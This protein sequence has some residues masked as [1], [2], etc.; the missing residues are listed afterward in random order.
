MPT[1]HLPTVRLR[2]GDDGTAAIEIA[3]PTEAGDDL[4]AEWQIDYLPSEAQS[5]IRAALADMD[6]NEPPLDVSTT[7][8][9][10]SPGTHPQ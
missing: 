1:W 10:T 3:V 4:V 5:R 9:D 6:G 8:P 7:K 2:I